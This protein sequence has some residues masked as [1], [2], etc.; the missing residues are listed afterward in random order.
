ML[1]VTRSAPYS[2]APFQCEMDVVIVEFVKGGMG[3]RPDAP[4][5][6]LP[7]VH[8]PGLLPQTLAIVRTR[9]DGLGVRKFEA[10]PAAVT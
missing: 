6:M 4:A 7:F 2:A 10:D 5:A 9:A 8:S 1:I 3:R